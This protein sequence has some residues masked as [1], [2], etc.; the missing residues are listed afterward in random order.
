MME[1]HINEKIKELKNKKNK[2]I[3]NMENSNVKNGVDA[4]INVIMKSMKK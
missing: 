2:F 3:I 1:K 4:I